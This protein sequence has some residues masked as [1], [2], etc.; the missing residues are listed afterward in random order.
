M[1]RPLLLLALVGALLACCAPA[2]TAT[3]PSP[4]ASC[5][6]SG[7]P[8][9]AVFDVKVTGRKTLRVPSGRRNRVSGGRILG[10]R[11]TAFRPGTT[12]GALR[13]RFSARRV[14]WRLG[15][16][17]ARLTPGGRVCPRARTSRS[18]QSLPAPPS[19]APLPTPA[20]PAGAQP[21]TTPGQKPASTTPANPEPATPSTPAAPQ[22]PAIAV[23]PAEGRSIYAPSSPWNARIPD[24]VAFSDDDAAIA[25]SAQRAITAAANPTVGQE[26]AEY[27]KRADGSS[28]TWVSYRDFTA[29]IT[30]VSASTPL[31]PVRLCR[32]Y[33]NSCV[34]S[35]GQGLDMLMRG[36]GRDGTYLGG[37]IPI[38]DGFVP[39]NDTDA[40]AIFYQPDYVAPDGKRGRVYELWGMRPNPDY[41]PSKPIGPNNA[42]W[43]AAWGGRLVGTESQGL[44][45]W[46]D[47]WWSGCGY[48]ANSSADPDM[49]GRPDSQA[50]DHSWGA[51]ATSL[52]LLGTEVSLDE[53]RRGVITH[54]V[55]LEVPDARAGYSWPAQRGDGGLSTKTLTEGM[56]L[57]FPASAKKP[58]GLTAV[59]SALWDAARH[60]GLIIDDRT[61]SS[62]NFR[63]E[64]G[65]QNTA[66]WGG[67]PAYNQ[68]E[69]FPWADLRVIAQGSA[70]DPNPVR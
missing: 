17:S 30:T 47:C 22:S 13:V 36:V 34:P 11:P 67:L 35:W 61:L 16:R 8:P 32:S 37:G 19:I 6:Q 26:L 57:T 48:Q 29:P 60:Y 39:P 56:R 23:A 27:S 7:N 68:L 58:G 33:P 20:P 2:A 24:N 70:S 65:C 45:Y 51:T 53:C 44:G 14:T 59:G 69:N 18:P 1:S 62:L 66:W 54:A 15:S 38:P 21:A 42:R 5:V 28:N 9:V 55:G 3:A 64:P 49:W 63:V 31:Q 52:S 10:R 41:D 43:R 50:R 12:R 46:T 40:E 25:T 4:R